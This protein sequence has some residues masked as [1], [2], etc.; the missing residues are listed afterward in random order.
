MLKEFHKGGTTGFD[1]SC[2]IVLSGL[3]GFH[4]CVSKTLNLLLAV[5][6]TFQLLGFL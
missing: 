4:G 3:V 1:Q 2:A 5:N 6:S